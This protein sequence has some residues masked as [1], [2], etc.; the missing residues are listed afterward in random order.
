MKNWIKKMIVGVC[1]VMMT[2]CAVQGE[3]TAAPTASASN[4]PIQGG[5]YIV[6]GAGDPYSSRSESR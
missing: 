2:A 6:R 5:T 4:E 1:A 3:N